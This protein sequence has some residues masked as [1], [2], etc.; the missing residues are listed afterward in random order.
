MEFFSGETPSAFLTL[1]ESLP[2]KNKSVRGKA[3]S[4]L[5]L[6]GTCKFDNI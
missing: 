2:V 3:S 1:P 5:L 4:Y 6:L